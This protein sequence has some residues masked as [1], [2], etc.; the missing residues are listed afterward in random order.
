M[1]RVLSFDLGHTILDEEVGQEI[2]MRFRPA[3]PMP[4]VLEVLPRIRLPMGVWANTFDATA[5]DVKRW[6]GRAALD[7]Y[8]KW[9]VTSSDVGYRKPDQRFFAF[10]LKQCGCEAQEVLFVGNQRNTDVKGANICGIQSVLLTGSSYRSKDDIDDTT[11][12]P[13]YQIAQLAELP[14]LLAKICPRD[15]VC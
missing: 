13:T 10:A 3:I 11:A 9:I 8:F 1:I 5:S 14:H 12:I 2:N 7:R 6:I 4:G 15:S